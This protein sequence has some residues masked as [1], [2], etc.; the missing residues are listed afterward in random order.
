M[1][2]A[3]GILALS[4]AGLL[5]LTISGQERLARTHQKWRET[6][7][8]MQAA[9]YYLLQ[10]GE[11]PEAPPLDVFPYKEYVTECTF[12]DAENLPE[13]YT[14]ISGQL[15]LRACEIRLLRGSGNQIVNSVIVDRFNYEAD[16]TNGTESL[17][18][19]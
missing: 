3:L 5:Q 8:L 17:F 19:N 16:A 10:K 6:H 15:P 11:E 7:M 18:N 12:R 14:G 13:S 4:L 1:A 9:E 2:V